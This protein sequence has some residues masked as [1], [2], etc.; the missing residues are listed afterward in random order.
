MRI[1]I[2]IYSEIFKYIANRLVHILHTK[3]P[4]DTGPPI[5]FHLNREN[6]SDDVLKKI[7][8][9]TSWC[10]IK[11]NVPTDVFLARCIL[12]WTINKKCVPIFYS[13][14]YLQNKQFIEEINNRFITQEVRTEFILHYCKMKQTYWGL[15]KFAKI[16]KIR[17][18]PFRIQTDLY[19]TELDPKHSSTF[20]LLQENGIY[21]FSFN[22]LVRIIVDAITHQNG[23][24]VEPQPVKNPYT[25]SFLSKP[26]LFNI[27]F[28]MRFRNMRIHDFFEKFFLCEFNIFEFRR[29]HET[30]L[31]DFAIE[32]YV[33]TTSYSELSQDI[34][35]MLRRHNMSSKIIISQWFPKQKL[36]N[37]MRPFLKLYLLER[38]SFSSMTRTYAAKRLELELSSFI[39]NNPTY[40]RRI[41]VKNTV[42]NANPFSPSHECIRIDHAYVIDV[43]PYNTTFCHSKYMTT[44]IYNEDIFDRY[45]DFGDT[46]NS[47]VDIFEPEFQFNVEHQ[48]SGSESES[49]PD[50]PNPTMPTF[51]IQNQMPLNEPEIITANI[52]S[53]NPLA[54]LSRLS[55]I[56]NALRIPST[57]SISQE[58]PEDEPQDEPPEDDTHTQDEPPEDEDE[59]VIEWD[60]NDSIS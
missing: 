26:D 41:Q 54:I 28:A 8:E 56:R 16:W 13:K 10:V 51:T 4:T 47:Y 55:Q 50:Q 33:N 52:H 20:Q 27:Y 17:K 57:P 44:H 43:K 3:H 45:V 11:N 23:M 1:N 6:I 49:E 2:Y 9:F 18:M 21:L 19:M 53:T 5:L 22:D 12:S 15:K 60:D 29:R 39:R 7:D 42:K 24:F 40:G 59:T 46:I 38:Y 34:D 25:N 30:E 32:Q 14:T 35:D 36:I 48:G 31:R 58:P 37:T